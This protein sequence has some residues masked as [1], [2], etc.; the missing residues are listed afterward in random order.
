MAD[1]AQIENWL[2]TIPSKQT[3]K[4]YLNGIKVFEKFYCQGIETLIGKSGEET[5]HVIEKFYVWLKDQGRTQNTCRNQVNA[6]IQFLKYFGTVP[7]YRKSLGLYRSTMSTKDRKITIQEVQELA[8]VSDLR[9]QVLLEIFLL[10]LRISDVSTLEWKP[11]EQD[12]FQLTTKKEGINAHIFI[13][14]EFRELLTK[15]LKTIDLKNRF[16]LQSV[17]NE[18]LTTKHIDWM[19]KALCKRAGIRDMHWHQG[20]KLA[21]RTGLELGIPNPNMKLLLGKSVPM[22]DGTYYAE[23]INLKPDADRLHAVLRLFPKTS[24]GNGKTKE[25]LDTIMKVLRNLVE[26]EMI[27]QGIQFKRNFK[28]ETETDWVTILQQLEEAVQQ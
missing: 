7:K 15:Y 20:R 14:E 1:M 11:F 8:K 23:N 24:N 3:R 16:L 18:H 27:R 5:G 28:P 9:E 12:E 25:A 19:L 2:G 4:S 6:P 21:F 26:Q 22:S 17:K 13:S 10:G